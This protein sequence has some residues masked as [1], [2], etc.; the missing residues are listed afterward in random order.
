MQI[1]EGVLRIAHSCVHVADQLFDSGSSVSGRIFPNSFG[2][3][4]EWC[5]RKWRFRMMVE[6]GIQRIYLSFGILFM[7]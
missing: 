5:L 7:L 2:G 6:L 1:I 3:H 4:S